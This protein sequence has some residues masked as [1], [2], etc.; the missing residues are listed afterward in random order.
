[1]SLTVDEISEW[2]NNPSTKKMFDEVLKEIDRSVS[3][4]ASGGGIRDTAD[5]TAMECARIT[6]LVEGLSY[7]TQLR[8]II[9]DDE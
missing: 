8:E 3:Y 5:A 2:R 6:G 7:I 1:M 4:I 9:E